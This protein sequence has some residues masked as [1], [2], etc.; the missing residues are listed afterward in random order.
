MICK[1]KRGIYEEDKDLT[2]ERVVKKIKDESDSFL[3]KRKLSL[4]RI[5]PKD[6]ISVS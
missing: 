2:P 6:L 5:K 1:G 3:S 4:K